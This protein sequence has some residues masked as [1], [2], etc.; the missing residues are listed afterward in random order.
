ML[1][2]DVGVNLQI[3]LSTVADKD[4]LPFRKVVHDPIQ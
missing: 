2:D 3:S 4:K 1:E